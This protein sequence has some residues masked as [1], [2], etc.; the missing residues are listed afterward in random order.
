M[1]GAFESIF[2]R[3][4]AENRRLARIYLTIYGECFVD[5]S[6]NY[7]VLPP[8]GI[9]GGEIIKCQIKMKKQS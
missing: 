6:D 3:M 5:K 8:Y 2:R 4:S 1:A 7:T 9:S